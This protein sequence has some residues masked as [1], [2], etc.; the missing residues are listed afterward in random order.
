[1]D[2]LTVGSVINLDKDTGN[3]N[4]TKLNFKV[5]EIYSMGLFFES[6]QIAAQN[7]G[8]KNYMDVPLLLT[9]EFKGHLNS[10]QQ[11]IA[12][13]TLSIEKTT[14]HFPLKLSKCSIVADEFFHCFDKVWYL[15]MFNLYLEFNKK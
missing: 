11:G 9:I 7:A 12:A 15:F 4:A 1:M 13:D 6:L 5:T 3:T 10:A 14:K 8:Y 2:N